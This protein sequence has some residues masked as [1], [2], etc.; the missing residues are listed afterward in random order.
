MI[1][2][3]PGTVFTDFHEADRFYFEE[4]GF[5]RVMDIYELEDERCY[6]ERWGL[7]RCSPCFLA[8]HS[9]VPG[10]LPQNIALRLNGVVSTVLGTD[11]GMIDNGGSTCADRGHQR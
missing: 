3:N 8:S 9:C 2:Y 4:L 10:Q 1:N 6:C 5:E 7:V 11:P